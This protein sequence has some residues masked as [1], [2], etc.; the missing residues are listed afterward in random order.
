MTQLALDGEIIYMNS[1]RISP[2][3]EI[4]EQ[5]MTGQASGT[6]GS[7]QGDKGIVLAVSGLIPF[8]RKDVLKRLMLLSRATEAGKRKIYR[9][10]NETAKTLTVRQVR[11]VGQL[12]ADE[13]EKLMA[14]KVTFRLREYMSVTEAK[15][16][17]EQAKA[18]Q[19]VTQSTD[20]TTTAEPKAHAATANQTEQVKRTSFEAALLQKESQL[21]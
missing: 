16:Q 10:G 6:D 11:F 13:Q 12:A 17:K 8:K 14:W 19:A 7:E 9:I 18:Q 20:N 4:R 15:Q 1:T 21:A 5:D 2:S 3:V